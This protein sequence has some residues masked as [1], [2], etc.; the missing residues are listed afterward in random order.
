[1]DSFTIKPTAE[2]SL[3]SPTCQE[4]SQ[5]Q[6]LFGSSR[7]IL[8]WAGSTDPGQLNDSAVCIIVLLARVIDSLRGTAHVRS[9]ITNVHLRLQQSHESLV[10]NKH[11]RMRRGQAHAKG[12]CKASFNMSHV[13]LVRSMVFTLA[14]ERLAAKSR[15]ACC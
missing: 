6:S 13:F 8:S 4:A 2:T 11:A 5:N 15:A 14:M 9:V 10:C 7:E 1:M 12:S 3:T